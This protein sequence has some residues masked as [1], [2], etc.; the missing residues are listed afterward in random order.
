MA[1]IN[2]IMLGAPKKIEGVMKDNLYNLSAQIMENCEEIS[3]Q[4]P[5][6]FSPASSFTL[7]NVDMEVVKVTVD[8]VDKGTDVSEL[9]KAESTSSLQLRVRADKTEGRV[10]GNLIISGVTYKADVTYGDG[11]VKVKDDVI[12]VD[13]GAVVSVKAWYLG[14]KVGEYEFLF[15]NVLTAEYPELAPIIVEWPPVVNSLIDTGKKNWLVGDGKSWINSNIY[16]NNID[17]IVFNVSVVNVTGN[18]NF[19]VCGCNYNGAYTTISTNNDDGTPRFS[20]GSGG[21]SCYKK[22]DVG[23]EYKFD[24]NIVGDVAYLSI[25]NQNVASRSGYRC[26]DRDFYLFCR[27]NNGDA[28]SIIYDKISNFCFY[29]DSI[30]SH[31]FVPF[32]HNGKPCMID[33]VT[34]NIH[35]N[36]GTGQFT[37]V[38][39]DK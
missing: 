33:L 17:R 15:G 22:L 6:N 12:T 18:T 7:S 9:T 28:N 5:E 30:L 19:I 25:N 36:Q 4:D 3:L 23:S 39:E 8:G 24:F 21:T 31:H 2:N 10:S 20:F 32:V 14:Q 34:L 38:T 1:N 27:N 29:T 35:E 37:I 26:L 13:G 11:I 16:L